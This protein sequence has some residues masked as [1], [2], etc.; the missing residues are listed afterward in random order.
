MNWGSPPPFKHLHDSTNNTAALVSLREAVAP[1]L[2]NNLL[3]HFTDHSIAHSDSLTGLVDDFI[4][5]LQGTSY[6]LNEQEL[7]ILYGAC[8][9]HDIGLQYEKAGETQVIQTALK[10]E[11]Q[12]L[13]LRWEDLSECTRRELLRTYHG[14]IASDMI[15]RSVN[16]SNPPIGVQLTD[17]LE[18]DAIAAI[19]EAHTIDV[20]SDRYRALTQV[21]ANVRMDLLTGVFRVVDILD[22]SRRRAMRE[23]ARTLELDITTQTHWWRHYYTEAIS[24]NHPDKMILL[25]F[26]FP[27]ARAQEYSMV[28]PELQVPAIKDE[29]TRHQTVFNRYSLV[30][31]LDKKITPKAITTSE[32]MPDAVLLAMLKQLHERQLHE[33]EQRR[34]VALHDFRAACPYI[35]RRL[36]ELDSAKAT[37]AL[38]DYVRQRYQLAL[39]MWG[40]GAKRSAWMLFGSVF[41]RDGGALPPDERLEVG[42]GLTSM[43]VRDDAADHALRVTQTLLGLAE[44]MPEGQAN[45]FKFWEMYAECLVQVCAYPQAVAAFDRA[46]SLAPDSSSKGVL[47]ARLA[48]IHC[49]QGEIARALSMLGKEGGTR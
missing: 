40:W 1:I 39:D 26:D 19:T 34:Q 46:L 33:Q 49:L 15:C 18:P 13:S 22:A 5:A 31:T 37:M 42:L 8:Y 4:E 20:D 11:N 23:K 17:R 28:V 36:D 30:W 44:N 38:A 27:S 35:Y 2:A 25:W 9:L 14:R 24:F 29:L 32:E 43:M 48:E 3:P 45:R 12:P 10:K 16:A 7:I 6:A 47:E 41:D 21:R